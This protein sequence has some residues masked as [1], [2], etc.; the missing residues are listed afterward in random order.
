MARYYVNSVRESSP[1][2]YELEPVD[3]DTGPLQAG[4]VLEV[5]TPDSGETIQPKEETQE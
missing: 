2:L 5:V 3:S 1:P 4:A